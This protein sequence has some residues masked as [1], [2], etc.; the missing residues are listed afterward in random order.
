MDIFC[1]LYIKDL[2]ICQHFEIMRE[3]IR[4][5]MISYVLLISSRPVGPLNRPDEIRFT[6]TLLLRKFHRIN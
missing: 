4:A 2:N 3:I 1:A 6:V 5:P